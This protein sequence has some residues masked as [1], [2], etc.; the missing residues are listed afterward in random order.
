MTAPS[1]CTPPRVS[2]SPQLSLS[3]T[4]GSIKGSLAAVA[5]F[6]GTLQYL[7]DRLTHRE[8]ELAELDEKYTEQKELLT[9]SRTCLEEMRD[10]LEAVKAEYD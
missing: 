8:S 7:S 1:G 4:A 5:P 10:P 6:T 2:C 9:S 3:S